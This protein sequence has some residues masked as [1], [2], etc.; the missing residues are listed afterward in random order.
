VESDEDG[1]HLFDLFDDGHLMEPDCVDQAVLVVCDHQ[2]SDCADVQD[3]SLVVSTVNEEAEWLSVLPHRA[4]W[5]PEDLEKLFAQAEC[6]R[7]VE[8]LLKADGLVVPP[9]GPCVILDSDCPCAHED[10]RVD[11]GCAEEVEA[12]HA[13]GADANSAVCG[14][15][16]SSVHYLHEV[17]QRDNKVEHC[18]PQ[19]IRIVEDVTEVVYRFE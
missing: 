12:P 1:F 14:R 9:V 3:V 17:V 16:L 11:W 4:G 15:V 7:P 5:Y 10:G 2:G 6:G 18:V 19:H 13:I 8:V